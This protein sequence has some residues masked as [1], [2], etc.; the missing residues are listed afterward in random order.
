MQPVLAQKYKLDEQKKGVEIESQVKSKG[1]RILQQRRKLHE[2]KIRLER[3]KKPTVE[4]DNLI[5]QLDW[6]TGGIK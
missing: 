2:T 5:A 3:D 4:I 6:V 1:E